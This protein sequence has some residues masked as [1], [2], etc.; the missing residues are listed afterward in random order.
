M[1]M[2]FLADL[3]V[4]N[5]KEPTHAVRVVALGGSL[6]DYEGD[7]IVNAANTGGVTGFGIDE[8]VNR[9]AGDVDIKVARISTKC[10]IPM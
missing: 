7:A 9:A 1:K 3:R 10:V 8:L 4:P 2:Q 5:S 6:L